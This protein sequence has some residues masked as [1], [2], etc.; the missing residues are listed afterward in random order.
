MPVRSFLTKFNEEFK[1][2]IEDAL[3]GKGTPTKSLNASFGDAH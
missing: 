1:T 3:E 2:K